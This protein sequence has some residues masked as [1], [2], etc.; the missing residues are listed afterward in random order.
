MDI[1]FKIIAVI[2]AI[3]LAYGGWLLKREINYSMDY[4]T[5]VIE[6]IQEQNKPLLKRINALEIEVKTLKGNI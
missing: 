5:K 2:V 6:T 3:G 4:K 1:L